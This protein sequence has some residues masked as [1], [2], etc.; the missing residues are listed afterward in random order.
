MRFVVASGNRE[1]LREIREILSGTHYE[2]CT[3]S[4]LGIMD[5]VPETGETFE[6]NALL[7]ARA[8]H[9]ITGGYVMAD[10]SGLAIRALSGAPGI[11]SARFAGENAGY[12][13]KIQKI[14]DMLRDSGSQDRS[15]SFICAIAVVRPDGSEF[16]VRGECH[17]IIHD[18]IEGS[19]GFGYDPIFYMPEYGMTTASMP[20][21]MKNRIS[22][23]G[24]ALR[25]MAEILRKEDE[26][27]EVP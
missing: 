3:K 14:W 15:A 17:G 24:I 12:D 19:N 27:T 20:R 25:R 2:I 26:T 23:R 1:K 5:D 18:R 10:D 16:T 6:E 11:Y 7:K 8:V 4:D 13:R 21:E 9:A 22:H